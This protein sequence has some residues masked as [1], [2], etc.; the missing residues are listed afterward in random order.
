[1]R[2]LFEL[3]VVL[4]SIV[5]ELEYHLY[6]WK[7]V[8]PVMDEFLTVKDFETGDRYSVLEI[9]KKFE[10]R[11]DNMEDNQAYLQSEIF[12]INKLDADVLDLKN[13]IYRNKEKN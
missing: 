7:S 9:L 3:R 1:M 2:F 4:W 8:D 10:E 12:K 6:P 11:I 5:A 13:K